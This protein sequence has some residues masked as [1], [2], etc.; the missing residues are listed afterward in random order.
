MN[1]QSRLK[2]F[3]FGKP[4]F[5]LDGYELKA[6]S[7]LKIQE[8]V[9]YL[10]IHRDRPHPREVLG[11]LLWSDIPADKSKKYLRQTFWRL[12]KALE[13]KNDSR[14]F[15]LLEIKP[16]WVHINQQADF[17]LDVEQFE[18]AFNALRSQK[19][20]T[21]SPTE[22]DRLRK[23]VELYR[24]E[25]MEGW[26]HDWVLFERERMQNMV[27]EMLEKLMDYCEQVQE[28]EEAFAYGERILR[29]DPLREPTHQRMMRLYYF[30]ENRTEALC[31]FERFAATLEQELGVAPSRK[32]LLLVEQIRQERLDWPA[33][34]QETLFMETRSLGPDGLS[35]AESLSVAEDLG[36]SEVLD[37]LNHLNGFLADF[38]NRV[39]DDIEVCERALKTH[40]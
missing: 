36:L 22:A 27:F 37:Y 3:L 35:K 28:Y 25:L 11:T 6:M 16:D 17:W 29:V 12:H 32:S 23:V 1:A 34:A 19:N 20:Q 9:G 4:S 10:L 39:L 40:H 2:I 13:G 7:S 26:Y 5:Q 18:S 8:L 33:P 15:D 38:Q 24:G 21:L 30:T 14:Q 31:H